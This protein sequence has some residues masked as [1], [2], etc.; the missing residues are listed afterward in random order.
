MSNV[1]KSIKNLKVGENIVIT[2]NDKKYELKAYQGY[3]SE[4]D[5][6]VWAIDGYGGMNVGKITSKYIT[7]YTYDMMS[8]R[9]TYKMALNKVKLG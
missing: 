6:S 7:L 2:Y 8:Q 5:Y 4:I 3:G 9:S 1:L